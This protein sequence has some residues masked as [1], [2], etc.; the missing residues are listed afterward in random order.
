MK[1]YYTCSAFVRGTSKPGCHQR[2]KAE[3]GSHKTLRA[4]GW[5]HNGNH[6]RDH[7]KCPVCKPQKVI[8]G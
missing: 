2:I 7:W 5:A 4:A 1:D 6:R 8:R 3:V